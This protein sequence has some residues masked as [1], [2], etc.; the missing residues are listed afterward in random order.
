MSNKNTDTQPQSGV[1]KYQGP[2]YLTGFEP[3][4]DALTRL[5]EIDSVTSLRL[6]K[7]SQGEWPG[8]WSVE[9]YL[10]PLEQT[11]GEILLRVIDTPGCQ[12]VA[13]RGEVSGTHYYLRFS[14]LPHY[15]DHKIVN[16]RNGHVER[17]RDLFESH[18]SIIPVHI[19]N[20]PDNIREFVSDSKVGKR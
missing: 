19:N 14:T 11:N 2:E 5:K 1:E 10:A 4:P 12:W 8:M 13:Y 17:L 9:D 7:L 15:Q 6:W 16:R 3:D 18:H 20:A